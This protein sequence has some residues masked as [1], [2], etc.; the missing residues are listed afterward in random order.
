MIMVLFAALAVAVVASVA[1]VDRKNLDLEIV[2]KLVGA[3]ALLGWA[4][5]NTSIA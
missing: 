3:V 2:V 4:I 1:I 5:S